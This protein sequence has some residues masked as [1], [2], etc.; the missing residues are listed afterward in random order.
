ME[1][2]EKVVDGF[3][4]LPPSLKTWIGREIP[5]QP[6]GG[7]IP[8]TPLKK[9]IRETTFTLI[10]SAGISMTTDPPFDVAREKREPTWGDPS[11]REISAAAGQESI[12]VNHLHIN[13]DYIKQDINV[14]LPLRRFQEFEQQGIIGRLAPTCYSYYGFQLDPTE[15]IEQSIPKVADRMKAEKVEAVLLTPA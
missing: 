12:D 13:T 8:W 9:P 7:V 10:T 1:N 4:F 3:R 2:I 11:Y 6:F 5:A 15:L 14:I